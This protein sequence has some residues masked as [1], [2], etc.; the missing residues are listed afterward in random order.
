MYIKISSLRASSM[1]PLFFAGWMGRRE[2]E[3]SHQSVP[4]QFGSLLRTEITHLPRCNGAQL[5]FC[6]VS[7]AKAIWKTQTHKRQQCVGGQSG[8]DHV[9][10][11]QSKRHQALSPHHPSGEGSEEQEGLYALYG[12][13]GTPE[14]RKF[15][16]FKLKD[17]LF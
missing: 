8:Q 3:E 1:T 7:M 16:K 6:Q 13:A 12:F 11:R 5:H 2:H 17:K 15:K 10:D 14:S 4:K 9:C